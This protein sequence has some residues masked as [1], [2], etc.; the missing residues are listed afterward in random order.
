MR[1]S[2]L[3]ISNPFLDFDIFFV[4]KSQHNPLKKTIQL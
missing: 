2:L 1:Q 3:K 4:K